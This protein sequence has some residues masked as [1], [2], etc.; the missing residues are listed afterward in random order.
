MR[1]MVTGG[2][3]FLGGHTVRALVDAGHEPQLLVRS[4]E[5]L[6]QLTQLFGL[7]GDLPFVLGD[8]LDDTAVARALDGADACIHAA[9]FTTLDAALM[10]Q[11]VAINGPGTRVVLDA[12]VAAGCDPVVHVSSISCIFPP[13]GERFDGFDADDPVRSSS[14]PYSQSKAESDVHARALQDAG[15]PVVIVYPGGLTGPDDLGLNVMAAMIAG[16]M[17]SD[18]LMRAATGGGGAIDVRDAAAAITGLLQPGLG[19]RRY[20]ASGHTLDW[21]GMNSLITSVSGLER[22]VFDVTRDDLLLAIPE[23]EAVDLMLAYQPGNDAPILEAT[24]VQWRPVEDT[25][26]DTTIWLLANGHLDPK[27]A[28]ALVDSL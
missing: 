7:P 14:A 1:V 22:A 3:G 4:E 8:M 2:T 5:K 16:L 15:H 28:P 19:P 20:V 18:V 9:A 11:C 24:G 17:A 6:G 25:Y 27:W 26:R 21:N 23:E 13:T 10:D 12:A